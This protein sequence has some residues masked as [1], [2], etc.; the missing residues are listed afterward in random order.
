MYF[1]LQTRSSGV[2]HSRLDPPKCK[3]TSNLMWLSLICFILFFTIANLPIKC[4]TETKNVSVL[5]YKNFK[6][7]FSTWLT[8][9]TLRFLYKMR[10]SGPWCGAARHRRGGGGAIWTI[11]D[12]EVLLRPVG[13]HDQELCSMQVRL[14]PAWKIPHTQWG[15]I[16]SKLWFVYHIVQP[17]KGIHY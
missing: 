4:L 8:H 16:R 1:L 15:R 2:A 11:F 6:S 13:N 7:S 12:N 14:P 3:E 10:H 5:F 9:L 17:D